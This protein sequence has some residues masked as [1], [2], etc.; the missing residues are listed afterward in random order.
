M[1]NGLFR[2]TSQRFSCS[3]MMVN[4]LFSK[5]MSAEVDRGVTAYLE[6]RTDSI[7][8]LSSVAQV[9]SLMRTHPPICTLILMSLSNESST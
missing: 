8:L 7:V 4:E 2:V 5:L 1:R 6:S 3:A 9:L